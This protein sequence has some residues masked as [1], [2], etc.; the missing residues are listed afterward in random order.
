MTC[1]LPPQ[2]CPRPVRR[3]SAGARRPDG[4][5]PGRARPEVPMSAH[6][7]FDL[8]AKAASAGTS[9]GPVTA[10]ACM[11]PPVRPWRARGPVIGLLSNPVPSR[12]TAAQSPARAVDRFNAALTACVVAAHGQFGP[13]RRSS[14]FAG[15]AQDDRAV[16][17]ATN[18]WPRPS[19]ENGDL[20]FQAPRYAGLQCAP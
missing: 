5:D 15:G 9:P 6:I 20:T 12:D 1:P 3:L 16:P 18:V 8:V 7:V 4:L 19:S 11:R 2:R 10:G 13:S 17:A 14:L